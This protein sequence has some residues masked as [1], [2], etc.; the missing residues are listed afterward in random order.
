MG[1]ADEAARVD[2]GGTIT[3]GSLFEGPSSDTGSA[4]EAGGDA[5]LTMIGSGDGEGVG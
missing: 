4:D 2:V 3:V 1:G 5:E